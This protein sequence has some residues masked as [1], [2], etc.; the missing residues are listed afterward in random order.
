MKTALSLFALL[1]IMGT[2]SAF[3]VIENTK[4]APV[5]EIDKNHS[6]VTFAVRHYFSDVVGSFDEFSGTLHFHP[7]DLGSSK[8]EFTIDVASVNTKNERRDG[9]L[10]SADFFEVEKFPTMKFTSKSIA[11]SG[12]H[13]VVTGDMTIRDVTKEMEIPIE[14]LGEMAHPRQEGSY[15]G[16]FSAEFTIDRNEFGVGSGNFMAT[17][18]IGGEVTVKLNIE[19]SRAES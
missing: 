3:T 11:K 2:F 14:F 4:E 18:T 13:Y 10:Q 5:W 8:V 6:S 7:E 9:H 16:G 17:T 1:M 15:I 12:E 19:A